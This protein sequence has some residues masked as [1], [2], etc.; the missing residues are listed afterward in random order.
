MTH[1]L[2]RQL[3]GTS[4]F[5]RGRSRNP[6]H[7]RHGQGVHRCVGRRR[8]LVSR[9][10]PSGRAAG[11]ARADRRAC[12]RTYAILFDAGRRGAGRRPDRPCTGRHLACLSGLGRVGG[13][14]GGA[15]AGAA[16][17]RRDRAAA[18][19]AL[20]RPQAELS[21]QHAGRA[22]GRRQ[23]MA[24]P[25]IRAAADRRRR[26]CRRVTNIATAAPR[27]RPKPMAR[28]WRRE[29][30]ET[31]D[32]LGPDNVIAFVRRNGRRRDRRLPAAGTGLFPPHPR[33]LRPP[34][35]PADR[36]TK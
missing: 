26:T 5:G 25:A 2:H 7:R 8:G 27:N 24:A 35:H 6:H 1:I 14:R 21:R 16:I 32:R 19:P 3:R 18:A 9:S 4:T 36:S 20:H 33:A 29:L 28:D 17:L 12:L 13:G 31:I 23:R 15:Q 11:H 10:R 30:E 22:R 34:R